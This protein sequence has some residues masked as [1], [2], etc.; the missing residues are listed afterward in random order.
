M[1]AGITIGCGFGFVHGV[2]FQHGNAAC[3]ER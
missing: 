2:S 1:R 3:L